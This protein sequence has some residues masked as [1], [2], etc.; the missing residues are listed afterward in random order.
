[1]LPVSGAGAV[2]RLG[3]DVQAPAGQ[4]G[5]RRVLQLGQP[6]LGRQEQVPQ[7]LGLGLLLQLLDNRRDDVAVGAGGPAVGQVLGLRGKD[8][9][10]HERDHAVLQ[11]TSPGAGGGQVVFKHRILL[12]KPSAGSSKPYLRRRGVAG[13]PVVALAG[14]CLCDCPTP[15]AMYSD[16]VTR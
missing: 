4:F 7:A 5:D 14:M 8:P 16:G 12:D 2:D 15:E 11:F 10:P 3:R 6:R 9:L 1:M 13:R